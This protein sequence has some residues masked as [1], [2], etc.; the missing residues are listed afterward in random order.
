M[1]VE[2]IPR[3]IAQSLE[4]PLELISSFVVEFGSLGWGFSLSLIF[5]MQW[6]ASKGVAVGK[7]VYEEVSGFGR[8]GFGE[9]EFGKPI[10][11]VKEITE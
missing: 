8:G 5:L 2:S 3:E 11:V 4:V 6:A 7:F 9:G 10:E 1:S